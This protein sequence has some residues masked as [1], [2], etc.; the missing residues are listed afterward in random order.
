MEQVVFGIHTGMFKHVITQ[1]ESNAIKKFF[2]ADIDK[3]LED[4]THFYEQGI[5]KIWIDEIPNKRGKRYYLFM[6]INLSRVSGT[7]NHRIMPYS[8]QNIKKVIKA[9]NKILKILLVQDK[10]RKFQDWTVERLDIAFDIYE[11]HT[12]LLM[13]LLNDSLDLSSTRKKCE[14]LPIPDKTP[15]Q[16]KYESMRFGNGSYVYNAYVKLTE[17]LQ[18]AEKNGR[19]VT[20][21]EIEETQNILRIERQNHTDA[22]KKML[23]HRKVADLT[24]D[25][26]RTD[27]LKI[28]IDEIALFFGTSDFYSWEQIKKVYYPN[29]KADIDMIKDVMK[30]ATLNSLEAAQ[31]D[32]IKVADTFNNLGLS[33]VGI[34]KD[35]AEQYGIDFIQGVY[36]RITA[37]F[38]RPPDKRQYNPFPIPHQAKN[39]GRI[40]ANIPLFSVNNDKRTISVKGNTLEDYENKVFRKLS[41]TYLINRQYLKSDDTGKRD[42][43]QKSADAVKRFHRAAKTAAA[44]QNTEKFINTVILEDEKRVADSPSAIVGG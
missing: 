31:D 26:V 15:E 32:Y 22:V 12:P 27:I 17:V 10:N 2:G 3:P 42:I 38:P 11:Q 9:V 43:V 21:G 35:D 29:H 33:P 7:G 13:Q 25:K 19:T 23:P 6:Q 14:R 39:D 16:L 44:K 41:E 40:G 37:E 24:D 28:M 18:K 34:K 8:I 4:E 20:Q 1:K 30:Q 36:N 5:T